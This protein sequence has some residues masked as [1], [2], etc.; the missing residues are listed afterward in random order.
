M[1]KIIIT[2]IVTVGVFCTS[3][4]QEFIK[5][6]K[7]G[8]IGGI[9]ISNHSGTIADYPSVIVNKLGISSRVSDF[10]DDS[11]TSFQIG[12]LA[13][14]PIT[15]RF[16]VQPELLFQSQG[17]S[18][19]IV[20]QGN[21]GVNV[22]VFKSK[23]NLNYIKLPIMAKFFVLKDV[24]ALEAGP[25]ISFNISSKLIEEPTKEILAINP[26]LSTETT[27]F[28]EYVNGFEFGLGAGASVNLPLGL[29]AQARYELGFS[30]VLDAT[31]IGA[32]Q[33]NLK[34]GT[35]KLSVGFLF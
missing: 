20:L 6:A 22:D 2:L 10:K 8:V 35:I 25:T 26:N 34:N 32:T 3:T 13:T 19:V 14:L 17:S 5:K 4:A 7:F 11:R 1:K 9:N 28:K 31:K 16:Y 29:F 30:K 12:V 21:T 15:E 24:L 33:N 18:G 27:N 23:F